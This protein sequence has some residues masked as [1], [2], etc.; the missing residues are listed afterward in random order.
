M[1]RCGFR[2]FPIRS[3]GP[4]AI[5]H[6]TACLGV[7]GP[8]PRHR[9][10]RADDDDDEDVRHDLEA[11]FELAKIAF[12]VEDSLWRSFHSI[13]QFLLPILISKTF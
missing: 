9:D 10:D 11:T 13:S 3:D 12:Y 1:K 7:S 8:R 5:R 2:K 4:W 6:S